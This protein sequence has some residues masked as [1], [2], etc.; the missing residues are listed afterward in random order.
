MCIRFLPLLL[1]VDEI[2]SLKQGVRLFGGRSPIPQKRNDLPSGFLIDWGNFEKALK[3][4]YEYRSNALHSIGVAA[5]PNEMCYAPFKIHEGKKVEIEREWIGEKFY[6]RGSVRLN[7]EDIPM[8]LAK[9]EE[10]VRV[11]LLNWIKDTKLEA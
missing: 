11:S 6:G 2:I 10:I 5:F 7:Q 8:N 3:K 9:F 4:I 1:L